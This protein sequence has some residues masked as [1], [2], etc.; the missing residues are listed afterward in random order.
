M[1][2]I[3]ML[4]FETRDLISKDLN[5]FHRADNL[6]E[7]NSALILLG[8]KASIQPIYRKELLESNEEI[9]KLTIARYSAIKRSTLEENRKEPEKELNREKPRVSRE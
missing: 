1:T 5:V 6:P 4:D 2:A 3:K 7:Q 9:A 8:H